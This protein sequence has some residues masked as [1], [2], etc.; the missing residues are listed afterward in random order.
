LHSNRRWKHERLT[1]VSSGVAILRRWNFDVLGSIQSFW[2]FH[3]R[4][5][6]IDSWVICLTDGA[7][8]PTSLESFRSHLLISP[9][10]HHLIVI[11]INLHGPYEQ[12]LFDM[13][14][15]FGSCY[16]TNAETKGFFVR[17][18]G[19]TAGI[20]R[21]FDA[22][23]SKIPVSQTF[24]RDGKMSDNECRQY[25][26]RFLPQFIDSDDMISQS[27]WIRFLYRRVKVFDNNKSFNYN[28]TYD[29]LG[30]SLM[31]IMLLEVERLLSENQQRD[32]LGTNHTQ[33][34]YDF[35][36]SD[37][38]EFRLVCT[39]PDGLSHTKAEMDNRSSLDL[40]LSQA[41]EIPR[42][43]RNDGTEVLQCIDDHGFILTV[44][45]TMKLLSI[46]ERITCRV[47]CLIEG[48][49]GVSKTALT[50]MYSI[51]RNS[52]LTGKAHTKTLEDLNDI[53]QLL[54]TEGYTIIH[55]ATVF[56][57]I[58]KSV[59]ADVHLSERVSILIEEKAN[60]RSPLFV[61]ISLLV[62]ITVSPGQV[63]LQSFND[64]VLE[65]TFFEINI[66]S[67]MTED[68]L[69]RFFDEIN[70]VA[71]RLSESEATIVV[72][73]DGTFDLLGVGLFVVDL[74]HEVG[75]SHS[76]STHPKECTYAHARR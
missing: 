73:L 42:R 58:Y 57:R 11:G 4:D 18:D 64:S 71:S 74:F 25:M 34:I 17:A 16:H 36:I 38:P 2:A 54:L 33:L 46:H 19:T 22:V 12:T 49:T 20:N 56:D 72:F 10:N 29:D 28:E 51:L 59:T 44:D 69:V 23:K 13:C 37:I 76:D 39:A 75:S 61:K 8:D 6:S 53:E 1:S 3:Q 31:D 15:K 41:L 66:D 67:L 68:D 21:A 43:T 65:N 35:T 14:D 26:S 32:W 50:K 70:A 27:F 24:E 63:L 52:S 40:F 9:E 47:P 55:A 60:K 62:D 30:S 5:Q 7:S 48:E 45:F